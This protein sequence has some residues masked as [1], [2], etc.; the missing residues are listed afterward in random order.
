[1]YWKLEIFFFLTKGCLIVFVPNNFI[2]QTSAEVLILQSVRI[3]FFG[4][5]SY[6]NNFFFSGAKK[7][8]AAGFFKGVGKGL[9]GVVARP[10]GGIVDFASSTLEGIKG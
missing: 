4:N 7:Q 5:I 6:I 9:V 10:A 8:G 1:M 2:T 3:A